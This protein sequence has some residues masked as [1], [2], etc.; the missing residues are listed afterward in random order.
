MI[1]IQVNGKNI[2]STTMLAYFSDNK[3]NSIT[4]QCPGD[5][6]VI[7]DYWLVIELS[8]HFQSDVSFI[9]YTKIPHRYTDEKG[10]TVGSNRFVTKGGNGYFFF[11]DGVIRLF[12][13]EQFHSRISEQY[14][15]LNLC[16]GGRRGPKIFYI[17]FC[18]FVL[19]AADA[20]FDVC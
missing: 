7:N 10:I 15:L 4:V 5:N 17:T 3:G 2:Y 9:C 16:G 11:I 20:F 13:T 19:H 8:R 12:S 6:G 14:H 18:H 1:C